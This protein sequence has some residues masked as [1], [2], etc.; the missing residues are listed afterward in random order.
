MRQTM[1]RLVIMVMMAVLYG[2]MAYA[3]AV[4]PMEVMVITPAEGTVES[5]QHFTI[6]FGDLPVVVREDSIP[7]LT[8]GGGATYSGHM[9][10]SDDGKTVL[11]DFDENI[12]APGQYYL[13]LPG[14]SI[15]VNGQRLLPLS[16]RYNIAGTM[17]TFY[18]QI[19]IDPAEGEVVSLQYFTI[20]FPQYV[21]EIDGM[22][23]LTNTTTGAS[24]RVP[25]ISA[26]YNVV[27]YVQSEITEAGAY[28]LTIP[29]GAVIIY[30]L[31]EEVHEL[32][33]SY[34]IAGG[35]D[36]LVGDVDGD[37]QVSIADVTALIDILLTGSE[38]PAAAD[39]DGD[40]QVSIADVT[41]L[42]DILLTGK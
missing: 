17:D 34:S 3:Q 16:L 1:Q 11:I 27:A 24:Y 33:F 41:S 35:P 15:I 5:L 37:G 18:E 4:D 2:I 26:G 12:T 9:K 8:K 7:T 10:A 22:G 42:I 23:T 36:V 14:W 31:G 25:L 13:N 32:N 19:S 39:V 28:T 20:S 40:G 6:T 30:T 29:A 21:A 38:A